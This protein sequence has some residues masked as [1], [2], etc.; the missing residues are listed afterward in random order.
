MVAVA[1][2]TMNRANWRNSRKKTTTMTL[3]APQVEVS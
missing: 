2:V 3:Y 1:M